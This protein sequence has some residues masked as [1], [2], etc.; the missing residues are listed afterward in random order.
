MTTEVI[1]LNE[2]DSL[3]LARMEMSLAR[4]RH[5]PV[6]R[7]ERLVGLVTHRDILRSMCSVFAELD[8]PEQHD[9]LRNIPVREI[10]SSGVRT[11]SPALS[12]ADAGRTLLESK[13]GC[14]PVVENGERLV[15]IITEADFVDLAVQHIEQGR[16]E[17]AVSEGEY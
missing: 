10:M 1:T 5:L 7:G 9:V 8:D 11:V 12:A 6:V 13:L 17:S 14:L 2:T 16:I 15:G 4:I 3:N